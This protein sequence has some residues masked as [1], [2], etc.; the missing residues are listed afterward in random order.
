V[1]VALRLCRPTDG[2]DGTSGRS[3]SRERGRDSLKINIPRAPPRRATRGRL[4][5]SDFSPSFS[6]ARSLIALYCYTWPPSPPSPPSPPPA[7]PH[8]PRLFY[9]AT[10][11]P[12]TSLFFLF[13]SLLPSFYLAFANNDRDGLRAP[14][15][16]NA[17][18]MTNARRRAAK[19]LA[20]NS[21]DA[22][23]RS[24]HAFFSLFLSFSLLPATRPP[25]N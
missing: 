7:L 9:L 20:R 22:W 10:C 13:P 16:P 14:R 21:P 1:R 18:E 2:D 6:V 23:V 25:V 12:L 11:F 3:R 4:F 19:R 24:F 15:Q 5:R 17:P 8:Y